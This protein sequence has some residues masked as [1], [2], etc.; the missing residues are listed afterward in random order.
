MRR[1]VQAL[2]RIRNVIFSSCIT[3]TSDGAALVWRC[4][5]TKDWL[6]RKT[7]R[8]NRVNLLEE[9]QLEFADGIR[10][11]PFVITSRFIVKLV[12]TKPAYHATDVAQR[13]IV[14]QSITTDTFE[15]PQQTA[16]RAF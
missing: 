9:F 13:P 2:S 4:E 14:L 10:Q 5:E 8:F 11:F 7:V 6:L 15:F 3:T 1:G 16:Q 12:Y